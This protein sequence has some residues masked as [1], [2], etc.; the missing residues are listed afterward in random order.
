MAKN[1]F[2]FRRDDDRAAASPLSLTKPAENPH[3]EI[4]LFFVF[5]L[6]FVVQRFSFRFPRRR[7]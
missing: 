1:Y 5:F 2:S 7:C 6:P 3:L 4:K